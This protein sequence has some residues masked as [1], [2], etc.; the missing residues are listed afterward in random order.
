MPRPQPPASF[1]LF[2]PALICTSLLSACQIADAQRSGD[3]AFSRITVAD[4]LTAGYA[5][6]IADIDGDGRPDILALSTSPPRLVWYRNPDWEAFEITTGTSGIIAV[7][8]HD[9]DGDGDVDLVLASEFS[10]QQSSAGGN[11]HWLENPGNAAGYSQWRKY[12]IDTLPT[13]HRIAWGDLNGDGV[14]ELVNLPIVGVG[15]VAPDYDVNLRLKAYAIP[16]NP[17]RSPWPGVTLDNNLQMAHGLTLVDFDGDSRTDVLTASFAGVDLF[18]LAKHGQL[19][20]RTRL[21]EGHS[22]ERPRIGASEVGL[23][24]L[25]NGSRFIATLEPWHGNEV[26]IYTPTQAADSPW[27]REVIDQ[28]LVEGHALVVADLDG[29]GSDEVIAGYRGEPYGLN[30]YRYDSS[31]GSWQSIELDSRRTAVSGLAVHDL[32]G[33][34]FADIIAVGSATGNVVIYRNRGR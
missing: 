1:S 13:S 8:P 29:D 7:A 17:R 4:D 3:L 26:V 2:K 10:L 33:D 25:A 32:D 6:E 9:I 11:L 14:M 18:Q 20:A 21:G 28:S 19:V 5:V 24:E 12:A 34:G 16:P 27:H 22:A 23:G 31:A 30:I 15:A